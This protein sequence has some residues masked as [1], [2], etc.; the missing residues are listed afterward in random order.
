MVWEQMT[1]K[2]V[3]Y[4]NQDKQFISYLNMNLY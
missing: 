4:K 1:T 2:E 3:S